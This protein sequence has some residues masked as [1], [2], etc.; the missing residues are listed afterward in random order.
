MCDCWNSCWNEIVW[1]LDL[2]DSQQA[3][4]YDDSSA[5]ELGVSYAISPNGDVFVAG[6]LQADYGVVVGK[7]D[8]S[9]KSW[10]AE[11]NIGPGESLRSAY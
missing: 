11:R 8:T 5:Y 4:F 9:S 10:A 2:S 1:E 6:T 3:D 7:K